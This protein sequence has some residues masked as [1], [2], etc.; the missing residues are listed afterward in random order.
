MPS[1]QDIP[2]LLHNDIRN[3]TWN[4]SSKWN[5]VSKW[6]KQ[7]EKFDYLFLNYPQVPWDHPCQ[8]PLHTQK[9]KYLN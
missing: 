9:S 5:Y 6:M 3:D 1:K 2:I 7:I 8:Q 4:K